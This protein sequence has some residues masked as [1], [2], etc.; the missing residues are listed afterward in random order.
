MADAALNALGLGAYGSDNDSDS[1]EEEEEEA[2]PPSVAAPVAAAAASPQRALPSAA[3]LL[4]DLPDWSERSEPD[5]PEYDRP[6]T[7]YNAVPLPT[8]MSMEAS[9]HN[10]KSAEAGKKL[11]AQLHAPLPLLSAQPQP[12]TPAPASAT[13]QRPRPSVPKGSSSGQ[14]LPP[15]L[16]KPNVAT[17]DLSSMRTAKRPKP[18]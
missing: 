15:Q 17:E 3:D 11:A 13:A 12:P 5:E 2:A 7:S 18:A 4:S 10:R 9:R 8:T 1:E 6:G 14:L 16:R